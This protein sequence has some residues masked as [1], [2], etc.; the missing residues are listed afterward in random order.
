MTQ[1]RLEHLNVTVSDP[2][3]TADRLCTLFGWKV[4]WQGPSIHGGLTIHVGTDDRYLA[5]YTKDTPKAAEDHTYDFRGGLNH[6]GI[7]V[8]HLDATERRIKDAGYRTFNHQDY[9]PGRR[10]YYLDEDNIEFEVIS[11]AE[12]AA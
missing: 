12:Y 10:F 8:D 9:A 7:V 3:R 1:G 6:I 4:R 2:V 11:Y 5:L